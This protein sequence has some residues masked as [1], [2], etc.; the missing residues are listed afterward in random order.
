MSFVR[1]EA[2]DFVVS[3]DAISATLWSGGA[4]TL[5]TFFTS[6]TQEAGSS[7]DFYL[8]VYQ[9]ASTDANA[10]VQF[11][12]AYGD[13]NGSGSLCYNTLVNG[14]SPT[15]TIYG[16]WQDLE[17]KILILPLVILLHLK[18]LLCLL[19]EQDTK[20]LFS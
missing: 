1:F 16:Q 11:A 20:K 9:T 5:T 17:M 7:G 8:N 13:S 2:D 4:T 19:K 14:K 6:S 10:A 18:C 15:S 12:I 3:S